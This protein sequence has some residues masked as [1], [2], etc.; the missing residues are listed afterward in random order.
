MASM[1]RPFNLRDRM[2]NFQ[3][4]SNSDSNQQIRF[5]Y[6]TR[7]N[8]PRHSAI[9]IDKSQH[10]KINFDRSFSMLNPL[11]TTSLSI[12]ILITSS[13]KFNTQSISRPSVL[14][15]VFWQDQR[16]LVDW[17]SDN[18]LTDSLGVW[19]V[20][21]NT[22]PDQRLSAVDI[23]GGGSDAYPKSLSSLHWQLACFWRTQDINVA[24]AAKSNTS[25]TTTSHHDYSLS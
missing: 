8:K 24:A 13:Q 10:L 15:P 16:I 22:R 11:M 23:W 6:I 25:H 7:A 18:S 4:D 12:V 1:R 21:H 14:G 2:W 3:H 17:T 5:D 19:A 9:I 20:R